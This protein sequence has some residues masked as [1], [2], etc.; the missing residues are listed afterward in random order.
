MQQVMHP[1]HLGANSLGA[2]TNSIA[3]G[4]EA[5]HVKLMQLHLVAMLM[6]VKQM[7]LLFG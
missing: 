7:Q 2:E 3:F 6:Q 1:S 5:K 4:V